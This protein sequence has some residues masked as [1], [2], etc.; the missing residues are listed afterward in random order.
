MNPRTVARD[1]AK[2]VPHR[3][4]QRLARFATAINACSAQAAS[5]SYWERAK[6]ELTSEAEP[7]PKEAVFESV[8]ES[9]QWDPALGSTGHNVSVARQGMQAR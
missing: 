5:K 4:S 2:A 1:L 6:R 9:E 3:L 8:P 7:D